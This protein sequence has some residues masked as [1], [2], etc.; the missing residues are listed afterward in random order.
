ME[1]PVTCTC[2][3]RPTQ[4]NG[5]HQSF[6][7]EEIRGGRLADYAPYRLFR[8]A[9]RI[10]PSDMAR[11]VSCACHSAIL[12]LMWNATHPVPKKSSKKGRAPLLAEGLIRSAEEAG[13]RYVSDW[14][15]E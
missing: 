15:P 6:R 14:K 7:A 2:I 9:P 12:Y 13:L 1:F 3:P 8:A 5:P 11:F 10:T 4:S